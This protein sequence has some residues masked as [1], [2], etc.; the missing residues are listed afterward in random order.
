MLSPDPNVDG[1]LSPIDLHAKGNTVVVLSVF[2]AE[3]VDFVGRAIVTEGV[4]VLEA[5]IAIGVHPYAS[6]LRV[7]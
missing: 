1:I 3:P 6:C 5:A 4:L 7:P 2:R